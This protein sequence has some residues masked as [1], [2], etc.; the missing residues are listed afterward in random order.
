MLRTTV[1]AILCFFLSFSIKAQIVSIPDVNFK[2]TLINKNCVDV[3]GDG[4][5][6]TDA[7]QNNNGEIEVSE[8]EAIENLIVRAEEI[9]SLDGI[10]AFM[11]LKRINCSQNL[12]TTLDFSQNPALE[13]L[14]C[15]FNDLVQINVTQNA[16]LRI[17]N[18]DFNLLTH[19]DL[20]QNLLLERWWCTYNKFETIDVSQNTQLKNL[21]VSSNNL[22]SLDLSQNSV[23]EKLYFNNNSLSSIDVSQNEQLH[24][25]DCSY[26]L[27]V[28]L[29]VAANQALTNLVCRNNLLQELNFKTGTNKAVIYFNSE[30]NPNLS[31]IEVDNPEF[32]NSQSNWIKDIA[33]EYALDCNLAVTSFNPHEIKIYPNPVTTVLHIESSA[34]LQKVSI[35]SVLGN[36]LLEQSTNLEE[37]LLSHLPTGILLVKVE[38]ENGIVVKKINKR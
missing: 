14:N 19:L 11:N 6:E 35:Y 24:F 26:N 28:N 20:T 27:M 34:T 21:N 2:D 37:I 8:A 13:E 38:N 7:D 17:I 18:C 25:L 16:Q 23:L 10:E 3:D 22:S 12:L 32:S 33:T 30:Q 36:T 31:C 9:E 1:F 5:P 4:I 15:F 29:N